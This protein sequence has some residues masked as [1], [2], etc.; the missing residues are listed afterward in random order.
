MAIDDKFDAIEQAYPEKNSYL[1]ADF[2]G[3]Y[4]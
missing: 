4:G 3:V 2:G 1:P